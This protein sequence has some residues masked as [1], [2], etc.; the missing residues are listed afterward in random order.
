M[1]NTQE[2]KQHADKR[3]HKQM[4]LTGFQNVVATIAAV[5]LVGV[6]SYLQTTRRDSLR[7]DNA[8]NEQLAAI[9]LESEK[10]DR[11]VDTAME[12]MGPAKTPQDAA[13]ALQIQVNYCDGVKNLYSRQ[14]ALFEREH[15]T[16]DPIAVEQHQAGL[17]TCKA[18]HDVLGYLADPAHRFNGDTG[19]IIGT[20]ILE[21]KQ[22]AFDAAMA[23]STK[24]NAALEAAIKNRKERD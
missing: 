10:L 15:K 6:Y 9:Q 14:N 4:K 7:D 20:G 19:V 17:A 11:A 18:E 8:F 13:A 5:T 3:E 16:L 22:I 2:K 12:R 1:E 23:R 24:A 21:Q